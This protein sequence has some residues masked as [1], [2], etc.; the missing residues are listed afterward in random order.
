MPLV[1]TLERPFRHEIDKIKGSRFLGSAAP[2]ESREAGMAFVEARREEFKGATHN[3]FALRWGDHPESMRYSDDGEPSGTAGRPILQEIDGRGLSD[4]V[5]V[6]T[7]WYG[8]TKLGTGG[9]LRA[10]A[11]AA[12][13]TLD[14][15]P[16]VERPVVAPLRF[17]FA[18]GATGPVQ[19]VLAARGLE[20]I[21]ATYGAEVMLELAVPVEE[22]ET[23]RAEIVEATNGSAVFH[24][25][26]SDG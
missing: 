3:C 15:A 21:E 11:A 26:L 19:A 7:R 23:V 10:Y 6:V 14:R 16:I 4:V 13:E 2:I 20:P 18:Y 24:R 9:L 1:R 17:T 12:A 5:V 8:G 22:L 25:A